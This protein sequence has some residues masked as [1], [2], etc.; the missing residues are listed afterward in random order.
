MIEFYQ[1]KIKKLIHKTE[2][3]SIPSYSTT[4][5]MDNLLVDLDGSSFLITHMTL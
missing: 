3:K 1:K 5:L 2:L 4:V